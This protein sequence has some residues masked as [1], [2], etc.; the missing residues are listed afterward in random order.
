[1][2]DVVDLTYYSKRNTSAPSDTLVDAVVSLILEDGFSALSNQKISKRASVAIG[3]VQK[4][5]P[6]NA[7]LLDALLNVCREKF[8]KSL[9]DDTV[10]E[11]SS[12]DRV[13]ML[14][15]LVWRHY[16]SDY[17]LAF[18]DVLLATRSQRTA[19]K[20]FEQNSRNA[21][22]YHQRVRQIFPECQLDDRA[23][24]EALNDAHF[25]MNGLTVALIADPE[26]RNTG[27]YLRR[28]T[29]ALHEALLANSD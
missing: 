23:L 19:A 24:T 8:L 25:L 20:L 16:Q 12:K 21:Q 28:A 29:Q 10:S 1:M 6:N 9:E 3:T 27:G 22:V 11:G 26:I 2:T 14:V 15:S 5:F 13:S 17:Y 7:V 18:I 4:H